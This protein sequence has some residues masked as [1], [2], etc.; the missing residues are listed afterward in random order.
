MLQF[1]RHKS[2]PILN[3]LS[4]EL[5]QEIEG[6]KWYISVKVRFVKPKRDGEDST[7]ETLF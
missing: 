4:K 3:H 6:L 2:K 7:T 1:V 5:K